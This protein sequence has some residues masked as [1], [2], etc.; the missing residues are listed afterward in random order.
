MKFLFLSLFLF[1]HTLCLGQSGT[2]RN[3]SVRDGL[4]SGIVYDCLQDREGFMW[5]ATEAG[6]AKFDGIN[7]TVFTKEDGLTNNVILQI[8]LDVDGSIW[9]FPFGTTPCIYDFKTK[10]ILN[11]D[12]YPELKKISYDAPNPYIYKNKAGLFAFVNGKI[13]FL[14][15]KRITFMPTTGRVSF[16]NFYSENDSLAVLNID[17]DTTAF[18]NSWKREKQKWLLQKSR[19]VNTNGSQPPHF[20]QSS[21]ELNWN[22]RKIFLIDNNKFFIYK[23]IP[24][25]K[26]IDITLL[27]KITTDGQIL[28]IYKQPDNLFVCTTTGVNIFNLSGKLLKKTF[29]G[30]SISR[31][32]QDANGN[33]WYCSLKG[34]GVYLVQKNGVKSITKEDNLPDENITAITMLPSGKLIAGDVF[35]NITSLSFK[36]DDVNIIQIYKFQ[37]NVREIK[38]KGNIAFGITDRDIFLSDG[39]DIFNQKELNESLKSLVFYNNFFYVGTFSSFLKLTPDLKLQHSYLEGTRVSAINALGSRLFCGNNTGLYIT[40][41]FAMQVNSKSTVKS[42]ITEPVTAIHVSQD[43][44]VWAGTST[45]GI[46][47]VY[48]EKILANINPISVNFEKGGYICKKIFSEKGKFRIWVA[49]NRGVYCIRYKRTDSAFQYQFETYTTKNG[50]GDNDVNDVFAAD[51]K[52]YAATV[53]GISIFPDTL[54]KLY[55]PLF[56]T[57]VRIN[58]KGNINPELATQS[59]YA[60]NYNENNIT[61]RF[62]GICFSC[63]GKIDY[64]YRLLGKDA[65]SLWTLTNSGSVEFGELSA[66]SYTFQLRTLYSKTVEIRITIKPA[67][68]QTSWFYILF[69]L[70]LAIIGYIIIRKFA[71]RTEKKSIEKIQ[72]NRKFAEL[73]LNAL[74]SQMNPHFIFNAMNTLQSYILSNDTTIANDYLSKYSELM[75]LFLDASRSKF[76]SLS[77]EIKL[78]QLYIELENMRQDK[79]FT[80]SIE[81]DPFLKKEIMI[82]AVIIQPFVENAIVHGL[83]HR[84]DGKGILMVNFVSQEDSIICTIDDNGI[85]R[86]EAQKINERKKT[87]YKSYGQNLIVEKIAALKSIQHIDLQITDKKTAEG[88]SEGTCVRIKFKI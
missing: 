37:S 15:K 9:I 26:R 39:T 73:E 13:N 2:I 85:G 28:S 86:E 75:R 87:I 69:V 22:D 29:S 50:L 77:S 71:A 46:F 24:T 47:V 20:N 51:G 48:N 60:L 8:A 30:I 40:D 32:F 83:R 38:A 79:A 5:F 23:S 66:G 44:L 65:D 45:K 31:F 78:L 55:I 12:N 36:N 54:P 56:I 52:V 6:L 84:S 11:D 64:E 61:I 70:L 57:G 49:T 88:K 10:R 1:F 33:E 59:S 21:S 27:S 81:A 76:V 62:T 80:W 41:T 35:G 68:W 7:F 53:K 4:P 42:R 58:K 74:Q 34:K 82:P 14:E 17:S 19:S 43:G 67:F 18:L 63:D 25:S 72:I 16:H 3:F